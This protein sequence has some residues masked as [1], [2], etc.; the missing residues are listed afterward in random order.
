VAWRRAVCTPRKNRGWTF[1]RRF[2]SISRSAI[3]RVSVE[4]LAVFQVAGSLYG[5]YPV[6]RDPKRQHGL[7]EIST[8]VYDYRRG[9]YRRRDTMPSGL[10]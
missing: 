5:L 1:R 8:L 3:L 7:F 6:L 4:F 9:R 2:S 10:F